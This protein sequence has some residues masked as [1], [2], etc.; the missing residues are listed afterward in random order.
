MSVHFPQ[1]LTLISDQSVWHNG[2][3]SIKFQQL[4]KYITAVA[5]RIGEISDGIFSWQRCAVKRLF[6]FVICF[7]KVQLHLCIC[8]FPYL[9]IFIFLS[10]HFQRWQFFKVLLTFLGRAVDKMLNCSRDNSQRQFISGKQSLSLFR[11]NTAFQRNWRCNFSQFVDLVK[12]GLCSPGRDKLFCPVWA[13]LSCYGYYIFLYFTLLL[14][15]S[16]CCI[17]SRHARSGSFSPFI[18]SASRK[19]THCCHSRGKPL[20]RKL[21]NSNAWF[22]KIK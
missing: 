21:N 2:T 4:E 15:F 16:F 11:G 12:T 3:A 18:G 8:L 1:V 19:F 22:A 20:S 14:H 5:R 10:S 17:P 6:N 7:L 9:S 13:R